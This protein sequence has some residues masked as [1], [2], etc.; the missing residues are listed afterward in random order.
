[1]PTRLAFKV[2]VDTDRGTRVGVP[3]LVADFRAARFPATFLFSLGPD[4]TG[5]AISRIF[6]PG[7]LRKV[8]RTSVVSAYGLRTLLNGTLLPAPHIGRRNSGTIRAV[9]DAGFE[10]GVHAYNHYRWQDHVQR[11][12][13]PQVRE[14]FAAALGEFRRIFGS[15]ARAAGAPGWQANARSREVYDDASLLY[16]SDSRGTE[17][18]FPRLEGRTFRTLEIPTTLPTFDELMGRPEYPDDRIVPH[19]V[20]LLRPDELNVFTLHAELEGMSKRP[21][22]G[23]L[24]A[25]ARRAGVEV[26]SLQAEARDRLARDKVPVCALLQG[27]VDGR[28]GTL[29]LQGP[30]A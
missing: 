6:R 14:E 24:L 12:S 1:M 5:R 15:E 27:A 20:S 22:F 17:P 23:E 29:A 8:G 21:L 16:G 2:D 28:S 11:M 4:Q 25:A 19:L 18:Y 10:V 7:F 9:R 26:V 30:S 3:N 13:L